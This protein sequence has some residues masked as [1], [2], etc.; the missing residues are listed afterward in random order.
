MKTSITSISHYG[1]SQPKG[2]K[3]SW[4]LSVPPFIDLLSG[5]E[6]GGG[7]ITKKKNSGISKF[8]NTQCQILK[9][10]ENWKFSASLKHVI[11]YV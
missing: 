8:W 11:K 10:L 2:Y 1:I 6:R 4:L 5:G 9:T 3:S 7:E